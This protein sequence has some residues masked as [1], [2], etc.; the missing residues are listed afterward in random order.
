MINY[1]KSSLNTNTKDIN[2]IGIVD[3]FGTRYLVYPVE[4]FYF[5]DTWSLVTI[6]VDAELDSWSQ[7]G[8]LLEYDKL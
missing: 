4:N 3:Q 2:K 7:E 1:K 8:E 5:T 6:Y